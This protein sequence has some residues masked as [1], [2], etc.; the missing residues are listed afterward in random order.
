MA[1][2]DHRGSRRHEALTAD[3]PTEY[4]DLLYPPLVDA[5]RYQRTDYGR[6]VRKPGD[7]RAFTYYLPSTMPR[8]L[9]LSPRV[10]LALSEAD[11]ALGLLNG[12]GRLIP[13][14][15]MLLGPLLTREALAS[16]RIEGTNASLS[17]VLK[18]EEISTESASDDVQEVVRYLDAN[19]KALRLIEDLPISQ[20]LISLTHAELMRGVR[21]EEK[22]PGELR[23][24]PVWVGDADATPDTA[25]F[26]PPLPE[27]LPELL[28][29]WEK[30]V[31]DPRP[32]L[33][34]LVR[35]ALM[36]Y[37]FETIHP[38]LDGNGR[39]GRLLIG[40]M[41]IQE[42]RLDAPILYLS[43][44]LE[45]RRGEYYD[46]LQLVREKGDIEGW[47]EFFL[48]AVTVSAKDAEVRASRLVG[49]REKYYQDCRV[50]R[51]R[52]SALIPLIFSNPFLTVR[53]VQTSVEVTNQGARNLL[54]RATT[55]GWISPIGTIGRGGALY[56]IAKDV[57]EIVD[58]SASY[59]GENQS[60]AELTGSDYK[61]NSR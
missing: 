19:K 6:P 25:K 1:V 32:R 38:F 47:L 20:R 30:F 54:Y 3:A 43:G 24:S 35:C 13:E 8:E 11:S 31:N 58:Q 5:D 15:N 61:M 55:F 46:C 18:A 9:H 27:H 7:T 40:L 44:Y 56:W 26:V 36:H 23:R 16:S 33:P 42:R 10:V 59:K 41:L 37:Q 51:S 12:L 53:R 52:V 14:P 21:G 17:E 39:I 2:S 60:S 29:D 34:T 28:T 50:D 49:L 4:H 45:A 48:R 57:F 22:F